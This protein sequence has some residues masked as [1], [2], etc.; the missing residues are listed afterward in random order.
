MEDKI[1]Q[2]K[3][4]QTSYDDA[5]ITMNQLWSQ[6]TSYSHFLLYNLHYQG[7]C[8]NTFV[9]VDYHLILLGSRTGAGQRALEALQRA[10]SCRG[11]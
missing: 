1:K 6:V 5:L 10:D 4:G 7:Y 3:Q 9:L 11:L 2:L 8:L